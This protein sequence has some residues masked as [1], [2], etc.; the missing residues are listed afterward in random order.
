[1]VAL[2]GPHF[3]RREHFR[4]PHLESIC[5]LMGSAQRMAYGGTLWNDRAFSEVNDHEWQ[6]IGGVRGALLCRKRES[7]REGS[8]N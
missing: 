2:K 5:W 3:A 4:R 1:M 8:G 7:V 6:S